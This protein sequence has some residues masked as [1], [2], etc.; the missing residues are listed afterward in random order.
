MI[1]IDHKAVKESKMSDGEKEFPE[2]IRLA[3]RLRS[4]DGCPWDRAQT[5]ETMRPHLLEEAYEVLEA[6]DEEDTEKY[7][8]ELGDLLFIVVF[9]TLIAEEENL[10]DLSRVLS[11]I[12]QKLVSRH[13]HV[14]GDKR[15]S[16]SASATA[17]WEE[18]KRKEGR[19]SRRD[20]VLAGV[21][22]ALPALIRARRIQE[23]A[24]AVGFDWDNSSQVMDKIEE[25]MQELR[26]ALEAGN[27]DEIA[28][29]LGDLIFSVV[30]LARFLGINPEAELRRTTRKFME[31][32]RYIE[33]N[34]DDL[35][36]ATLE[37][38]ERLW[39][40]SKNDE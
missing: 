30:N 31:R 2:L 11:S 18:A 17:C 19:H 39:Q 23:K 8:D 35:K 15:A 7:A 32:F 9:M 24:S 21:P 40:T 5:S 38:M 36:E 14:F 12:S 27:R 22:K 25:E 6:L 28:G 34:V 26:S 10:F 33:K 13:P 1:R 3:R 29:E 37:Q 20:S 16:D 4:Q